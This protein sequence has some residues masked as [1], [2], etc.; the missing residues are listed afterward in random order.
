VPFF[1]RAV[2]HAAMGDMDA[3]VELLKKSVDGREQMFLAL[4]QQPEMAP[5]V[6]DPR[7]RRILD[8]VEALRKS[9]GL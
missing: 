6:K 8:E 5:L 1:A 9:N 4:R 7:A 3:A 2:L